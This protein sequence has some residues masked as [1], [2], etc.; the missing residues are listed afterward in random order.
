MY[1]THISRCIARRITQ[2]AKR[3]TAIYHSISLYI[4]IH[5]WCTHL[6]VYCPSNYKK[7]KAD[8]RP[9]NGQLKL[10]YVYGIRSLIIECV[11]FL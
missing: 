10:D 8:N 3:T 11:L 7:S 5:V 6:Q 9:P 1:G 2:R 4:T